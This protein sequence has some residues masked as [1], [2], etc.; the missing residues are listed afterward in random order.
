MAFTLQIIT[1]SSVLLERED[2][3]FLLLPGEGG[4]LGVLPGHA[5]LLSGL[6]IGEAS[7]RFTGADEDQF[8]YI[9]ISGGFVHVRPDCVVILADAAELA[10]DI[11]IERARQARQRAEKRLAEAAHETDVARAEAALARAMNR[12]TVAERIT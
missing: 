1:P 4:E 6:K 3:E 10:E 7:A 8:Q 12:L 11:D 2:T 9:G 5:P